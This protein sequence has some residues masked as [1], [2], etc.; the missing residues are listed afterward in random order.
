M[1]LAAEDL[2]F[3]TALALLDWQLGMGAFE[4]I[5]D[6]PVDRYA[7]VQA[8]AAQTSAAPQESQGPA[9]AG[10]TAPTSGYSDLPKPAE[11]DPA[12]EA[13]ALAAE[14]QSLEALAAAM[15]SF[16]LCELKRGARQLVFA[17]G[18][19]QADVMIIGEAPGREEDRTGRPLVGQA[20]QMLDRMLS[21]IGLSREAPDP[22][23]AVYIANL[24][25]WRA[26]ENRE[27]SPKEVSMMLPFLLRHIELA[28]PK[29][30]VL[31]GGASVQAL[32]GQ[33]GITRLRGQ[34]TR[35]AGLPALPMLHPAYLLRLPSEKK[36][37]WA[38]LLTL[39]AALDHGIGPEFQGL[40]SVP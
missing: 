9:S 10:K 18:M 13:R 24:L 21:A 29:V 20:G 26:P 7:L 4:A 36:R 40:P 1:T 32:T 8:A 34:W 3:D 33:K 23:R 39:R 5:S 6:L 31:M 25:P 14:A 17:D 12:E 11:T 19:P 2:D 27:P 37:A 22:S 28:Q 35:A 38:D 15:A 30:L 16:D